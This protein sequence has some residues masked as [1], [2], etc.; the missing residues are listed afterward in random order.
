MNKLCGEDEESRRRGEFY[1]PSRLIGSRVGSI[2]TFYRACIG[3]P[4]L[5]DDATTFIEVEWKRTRD[6][7][8]IRPDSV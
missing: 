4:V 5:S 2:A 8:R 6:I 7:F 1:E 3:C